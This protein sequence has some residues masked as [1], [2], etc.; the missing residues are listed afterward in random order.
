MGGEV[1]WLDVSFKNSWDIYSFKLKINSEEQLESVIK[2]LLI[3]RV[4]NTFLL[5]LPHCLLK[6][7]AQPLRFIAFSVRI[8][9]EQLRP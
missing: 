3:E 5:Q 1:L 8:K 6:F 9:M 2:H 4:L 7:E